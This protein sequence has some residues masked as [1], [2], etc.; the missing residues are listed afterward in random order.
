MDGEGMSVK[1]TVPPTASAEFCHLDDTPLCY[2][3]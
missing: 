1:T 2:P 3:Y